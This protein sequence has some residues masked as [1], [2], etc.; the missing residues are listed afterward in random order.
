MQV[1]RGPL[2]GDEFLVIVGGHDRGRLETRPWR[3][4]LST[5]VWTTSLPGQ[6]Q[7]Q[8]TYPE[9][10]PRMFAASFRVSPDWLLIHGG[11]TSMVRILLFVTVC[12]D[13]SFHHV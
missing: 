9:I 7:L 8:N 3:L 4:N 10:P 11:L 6:Q 13:M 5:W 2:T 1:W 12:H